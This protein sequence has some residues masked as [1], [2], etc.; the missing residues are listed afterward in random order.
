M[1]K[2]LGIKEHVYIGSGCIIG[3]HSEIKANVKVWPDKVIE[4][5]AILSASLVW[6]ERWERNLFTDA[7]IS[8][9]VNYEMSPEV[10][11]RIASALGAM[12]GTGSRVAVSRD[13]SSPARMVYRAFISGLMSMGII[14]EDL[15]ISLIPIIRNELR[16]GRYQGGVHVRQSPV[17]DRNVD[18]IFFDTQGYDFSP[19][20][21]KSVEGHFFKESYRRVSPKQIGEVEFTVRASEKYR[22]RFLS[23]LNTG[24][25][26]QN[27]L[28][29]VID[30]SWGGAS[31]IFPTILGEMG[32]EII[33]LNAYL[34]AAQVSRSSESM[35]AGLEQLS[36]IVTSL[37]AS[38]G[39]MVKGTA[40]SI[41]VIDERGRFIPP[42]RLL[43]LILDYFLR[44]NKVK[45]V[46]FPA[47]ATMTAD[48]VAHQY[49]VKTMMTSLSA[50][51][52]AS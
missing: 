4:S 21:Q 47:C 3:D 11:A 18:I 44:L 23:A 22:E 29:A 9:L 41:A 43:V 33:S 30:Y 25:F 39:F 12:I 5:G 16:S 7:K 42:Q 31:L 35:Q 48:R 38:V 20:L 10:S 14:V 28:K 32:C 19:P 49:G 40:E 15:R 6:G 51:G 52:P 46:A 24:V 45:E 1:K 26:K 2:K 50:T 17:D 34:D 36:T 37:G 8:G 27:P 13:H